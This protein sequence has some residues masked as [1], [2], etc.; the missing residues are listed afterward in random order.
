MQHNPPIHFRENAVPLS[1]RDAAVRP[2]TFNAQANTVECVVATSNPVRRQDA[3][4]A[5]FL[6][7][8]SIDG[9][10]LTTLRGAS[11]LNSHQQHGLD[12]VLGTVEECWREQNAII[13]R[14]RLS[15][16]PEV[17]SI[18]DDI[19]AGIL[20]SVSIGYEVSQW[21]DGVGA[22]GIAI[23]TATAWRP[24]KSR[25]WPCLPIRRLGPARRIA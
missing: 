1:V 9:A 23:R 21:E 14:V 15:T 17:A 7:V 18:V 11:V 10:D 2:A 19:R 6:E 13:A 4:G 8:L 16:R 3:T 20:A 25:S 5:E 24:A 12:N 22:N